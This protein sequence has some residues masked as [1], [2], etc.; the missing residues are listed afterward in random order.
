MPLEAE[1]YCRVMTRELKIQSTRNQPWFK[2][3]AVREAPVKGAEQR[4]CAVSK[5]AEH[6]STN[7]KPRVM[8]SPLMHTDTRIRSVAEG[9]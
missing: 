8:M 6:E 1:L 9:P 7:K 3:R 5:G 4:N 2:Y